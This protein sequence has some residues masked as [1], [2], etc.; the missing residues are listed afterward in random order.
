MDRHQHLLASYQQILALSEHMLTL[1]RQGLW[2]QLVELEMR[3]L[4]A[5]EATSNAALTIPPSPA[6][7]ETLH[8]QLRL[9][10]A[11]EAELKLLLQ[12]RLDELREL[13][14]QSSRQQALNQTYGQFSRPRLVGHETH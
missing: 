11:N 13:V 5:V 1:A 4:H 10:L 6:L 3:Y 14:G 7:Q 9:I 2:D 12:Q 8:Q